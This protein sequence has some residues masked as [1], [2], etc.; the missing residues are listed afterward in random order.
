MA[1]SVDSLTPGI[2]AAFASGV[3]GAPSDV[4]ADAITA[5]Y[6]LYSS[7]AQSCSLVTPS[8]VQLPALKSKM[9]LALSE[10]GKSAVSAAQRWADAVEAYW[11]GAFF[12]TTGLVVAITGT[13]GLVGGLASIF[14]NTLNTLPGAAQQISTELDRFTKLVLVTDTVLP[15]PIGCGPAPIT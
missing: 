12:G 11:T 14:S 13:T 2:T 5:A 4:V 6:A 9:R 8:V 15:I 10:T 7:T 3:V 1:L